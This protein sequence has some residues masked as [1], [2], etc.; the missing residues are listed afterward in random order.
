[1][2]YCEYDHLNK[3]NNTQFQSYHYG[4]MCWAYLHMEHPVKYDTY[5]MF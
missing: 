4:F 1:M 2:F 3:F 5:V